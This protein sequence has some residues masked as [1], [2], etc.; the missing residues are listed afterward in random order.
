[1]IKLPKANKDEEKVKYVYAMPRPGQG[2]N[3]GEVVGEKFAAEHPSAVRPAPMTE[4]DADA[5]AVEPDVD[6]TKHGGGEQ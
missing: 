5:Q 2:Y 1:M 6:K 3:P 4:P